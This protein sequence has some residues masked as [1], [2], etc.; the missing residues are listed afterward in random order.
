MNEDVKWL[1][2]IVVLFFFFWFVSGGPTSNSGVSNQNTTQESTNTADIQ[3]VGSNSS[4]VYGNQLNANEIQQNLQDAGLKANEIQAEIDAL[5]QASQASPLTG[6][7]SIAGVSEGTGAV[8][9]EYVVVQASTANTSQVLLTGLR[10]QSS[11]SGAGVTIPRGAKLP[12]QNQLNVE[13]PI[14]LKPG[15]MAY[16]ITGGS[17]LGISFKPNMCTG[18]FN[19]YQSFYPGLPSRCPGPRESD[20]PNGPY[21]FNDACRDY[22]SSL[23]GCYVITD[24]PN[25]ISPECQKF[26]TEELS[27]TKCVNRYKN[28]PDFYDPDWRVYL[29]RSSVLWKDRR[30]LIKLLDQ[31]G[32]TIDAITY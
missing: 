7:L 19:Q 30:E 5:Q 14:Y 28:D 21:Q 24:P 4:S 23:P 10:L 1:L 6:K 18:F 11:A 20:L 17:P 16:I 27:Y 8:G 32:K 13:E 15:E 12:F 26:V 25:D 3:H 29:N 2:G 9:S 31:N 22:I